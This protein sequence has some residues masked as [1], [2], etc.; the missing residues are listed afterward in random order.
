MFSLK[1]RIHSNYQELQ[2]DLQCLTNQQNQLQHSSLQVEMMHHY[3]GMQPVHQIHQNSHSIQQPQNY[4]M[5]HPQIS[6]GQII[7][8]LN[9][10]NPENIGSHQW[11]SLINHSQPPVNMCN[12]YNQPQYHHQ[13]QYINPIPPIAP[14]TLPNVNAY[15]SVNNHYVTQ[16]YFNQMDANKQEPQS[17]QFF[18]HTNH[19][20]S[21]QKSRKSW[22]ISSSSQP[23][24]LSQEPQNIW[25][26]R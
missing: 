9:H 15:S 12:N 17:Q 23:Q 18:L 6:N 4:M 5:N 7:Q 1:T 24:T 20:E 14:N 10:N 8:H 22:D 16:E 2:A 19:Q 25:N 13:Q 26:G 3:P 21:Q 11:H